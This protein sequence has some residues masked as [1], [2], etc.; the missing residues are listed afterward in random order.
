MAVYD[1]RLMFEWGGGV[2]WGMNPAAKDKY[3]YAECEKT[4]PLS[5][6]LVAT[7]GKLS[8]WHD[9][10]L[11]W[12]NPGN[13]S[14]WTAGQFDEFETSAG[15]ILADIQRELGPEFHVWYSRLGRPDSR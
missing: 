2:L 14:P 1:I 13:P 8:E 7:L 9:T 6:E 4:L 11:D 3:G 10:A 5:C 15:S 12:A